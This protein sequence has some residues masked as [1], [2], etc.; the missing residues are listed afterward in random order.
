MGRIHPAT[1]TANQS[2]CR[3]M[4]DEVVVKAIKNMEM[5]EEWKFH[6]YDFFADNP[7]GI[8]MRFCEEYGISSEELRAFYE[9]FVRPFCRNRHLEEV[10][11][12]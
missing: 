6:I 4:T 1:A 10:W 12:Y 2:Y 7:P 8:L 3:E 11:K 9:R 5:P